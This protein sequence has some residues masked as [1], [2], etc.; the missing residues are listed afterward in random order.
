MRDAHGRVGLVDVLASR[1]TRAV[2]VDAEVGVVDLDRDVV[3]KQRRDHDL[4]ES[5]MPPVSGVERRQSH[6]PV[7]AAL[8]LERPVG[9]LAAHRDGGRLEPGFLARARLESLGLEPAVVGPAQV[10]PEEHLCPVLRVRAA[11]TGVDLEQRVTCVVLAG[12]ER[13]LLQ[14]PELVFEW[15]ELL[16]DVRLE[17]RVERV[18]LVRVLELA[19]KPLVS[20]QPPRQAGVLGGDP[21][22]RS[23]VVPEARLAHRLLELGAAP[24]ES[25]GVKGNHGPRRAGSRSPRDARRGSASS[26]PRADRSRMRRS[27]SLIASPFVREPSRGREAGREPG[28]AEAPAGEHVGHVVDVRARCG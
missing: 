28:E 24:S 18:E 26:R 14:S 21:G 7:D 2:G 1:S 15:A 23:L 19:P 20:V 17:R 16:G 25:V 13:V 5:R 4:R 8:R 11:R 12:E 3:G 27:E 22:S 10:H 9:V 6:E